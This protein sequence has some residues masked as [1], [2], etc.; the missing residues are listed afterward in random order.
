MA[1]LLTLPH[2]LQAHL[3]Q[4]HRTLTGQPWPA[5]A[6]KAYLTQLL[7]VLPANLTSAHLA[8]TYICMQADGASITACL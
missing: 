2:V 5:Q 1:I 3:M 8:T 6:L 7:Q 4:G